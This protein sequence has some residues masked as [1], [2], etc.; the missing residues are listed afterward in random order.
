MHPANH[1]LI[2][3]L[4]HQ[5]PRHRQLDHRQCSQRGT[6]CPALTRGPR[7]LLSQHGLSQ[8]GFV[9]VVV[10]AVVVVVVIIIIIIIMMMIIIIIIINLRCAWR[11]MVMVQMHMHI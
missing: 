8:N 7:W 10:V 5:R 11:S 3:Q 1:P 6:L 2:W 9:V 4:H